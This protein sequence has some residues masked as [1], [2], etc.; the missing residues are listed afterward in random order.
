MIFRSA[1]GFI[2]VLLYSLGMRGL[3]VVLALGVAGGAMASFDLA[4][5]LDSGQGV[6]HRY[7]ADSGVYL[8]NFGGGTFGIVRGIT[9]DKESRTAFVSHD[10]GYSAWDYNTGF[11][12][13]YNDIVGSGIGD[14]ALTPD[15]R[16]LGASTLATST[17]FWRI[18]S[19]SFPAS[20]SG[21]FAS[22]VAGPFTSAVV[23]P[24]GDYFAVKGST[25][26]VVRF[27]PISGTQTGV[28]TVAQLVGISKG[29]S[30][31][32][33]FVGLNAV[34]RAVRHSF[35]G[36][37]GS[38]GFP[39]SNP[40]TSAVE[41][42]FGHAGEG[43]GL[44]VNASGTRLQRYFRNTGGTGGFYDPIGPGRT[45]SQVT[46]PAGLAIVTAPEPGTLFALGV[47]A[48]ALLRRRRA[49]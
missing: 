47:G 5:V 46:T 9:V 16:L 33:S 45:L 37:T 7:D 19:F 48:A 21:F 8:G 44:G 15:G 12:K 32:T 43:W 31:G 49:R 6:V 27:N 38:T 14:L 13:G 2:A 29:A 35:G 23:G 40:F 26:E 18:N 17:A 39:L 22:T 3:S 11:F 34:G 36:A 42:E 1:V 10:N 41:F 20:I 24:L 25:G 30:D 28:A 4:L